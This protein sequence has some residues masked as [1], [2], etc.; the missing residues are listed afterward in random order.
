MENFFNIETGEIE[1]KELTALTITNNPKITQELQQILIALEANVY[2][3]KYLL[4]EKGDIYCATKKIA[5]IFEEYYK[6]LN[7]EENILKNCKIF[8]RL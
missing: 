7:K 2:D 3:N 6:E 5:N 4:H 1:K 8:I